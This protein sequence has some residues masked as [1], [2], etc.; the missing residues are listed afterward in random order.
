MRLAI[1]IVLIIII[2]LSLNINIYFKSFRDTYKIYIKLGTIFILIPH[3]KIIK[4]I[5][6]KEKGKSKTKKINDVLNSLKLKKLIL[7]IFS[8]STLEHL[9]IAKF[10]KNIYYKNYSNVIY[11]I[12]ASNIR[13]LSHSYFR[14]INKTNLLL[15]DDKSYEN[16][17]YYIQI[18]TNIINLFL[19]WILY[20]IKE[21]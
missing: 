12:I 15:N 6:E 9:Y 14:Y 10:S 20:K 13:G 17:D 16:I 1:L 11:C 8:H 19:S 18:K 7:I 5:I 4:S 2:I 3:H 21:R